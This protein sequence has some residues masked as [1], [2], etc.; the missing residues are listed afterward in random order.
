MADESHRL[1]PHSRCPFSRL[2]RGRLL[3]YARGETGTA[4][5]RE[6]CLR[7][8][9]ARR[10]FHRRAESLAAVRADRRRA[11]PQARRGGDR[12]VRLAPAGHARDAR[13]ARL[14]ARPAARSSAGAAAEKPCLELLELLRRAF[15]PNAVRAVASEG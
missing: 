14:V 4:R 7:W 10:E 8:R 5:A 12:G 11:A 13:R 6:A 9:D 15:L 1:A 2:G 3:P